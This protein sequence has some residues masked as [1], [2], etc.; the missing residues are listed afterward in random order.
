MDRPERVHARL[1]WRA[2]EFGWRS[3]VNDVLAS[4]GRDDRVNRVNESIEVTGDYKY[5]YSKNLWIHIRDC[6]GRNEQHPN[7]D[8]TEVERLSL[9]SFAVTPA[10]M[11]SRSAMREWYSS[12]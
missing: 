12:K 9:A 10:H 1:D 8:A 2:A 11:R 4:E 7:I 5:A 3:Q 6:L